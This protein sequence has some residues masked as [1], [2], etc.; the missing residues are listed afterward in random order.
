MAKSLLLEATQ[1][2]MQ[3]AF[4][5]F[6]FIVF[7]FAL[8]ATLRCAKLMPAEIQRTDSLVTEAMAKKFDNESFENPL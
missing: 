7:L 1:L 5:R 8:S 3:C 4:G 2:T 6:R